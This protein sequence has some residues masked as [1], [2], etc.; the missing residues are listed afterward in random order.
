MELKAHSSKVIYYLRDAI[1]EA[2]LGDEN[3]CREE[4]WDMHSS[5][6]HENSNHYL[7][8]GV[9]GRINYNSGQA[10]EMLLEYR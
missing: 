7:S 9:D 3:K 5:H 6:L 10:N 2:I 8:V 1:K 4:N